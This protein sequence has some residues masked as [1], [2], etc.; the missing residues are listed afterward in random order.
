MIIDIDII[1]M[2]DY[3][4]LLNELHRRKYFNP[5]FGIELFVDLRG[6]SYMTSPQG[7]VKDFVTTVLRHN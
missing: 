5:A 6:R 2:I 1:V 7:G 3:V 4:L